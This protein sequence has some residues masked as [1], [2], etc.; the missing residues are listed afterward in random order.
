MNHPRLKKVM[1]RYPYGGTCALC[2]LGFR[3]MR[4]YRI[5]AETYPGMVE[6]MNTCEICTDALVD[7]RCHR[8]GK[9]LFDEKRTV[10]KYTRL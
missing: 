10:T 4:A 2:R 6:P 5:L 3:G 8:I 1:R 7:M 9:V